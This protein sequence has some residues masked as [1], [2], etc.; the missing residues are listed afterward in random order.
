MASTKVLAQFLG[1]KDFPVEWKNDGEKE[2]FWFF[3]DNH[4]PNPISPMYF[5]LHGWW[6]PTCE[7]MLSRFNLNSGIAWIAKRVNGYVY[8]AIVPRDS[9]TPRRWPR[10]TCGSCPRTRATACPGGRSAISRR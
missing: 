4:C 7:Y 1:D 2:L 3:D 10:T 6:G 8:T 5:S 9:R